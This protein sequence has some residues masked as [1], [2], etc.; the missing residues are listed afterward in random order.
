MKLPKG[1]RGVRALAFSQDAKY[2]AAVDMSNNHN[3]Y[4]FDVSS[5]AQVYTSSGDTNEIFDLAF[6]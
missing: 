5:G 1:S 2:L 4:C 3:I 6:S